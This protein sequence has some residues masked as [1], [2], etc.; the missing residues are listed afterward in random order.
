MIQRVDITFYDSY[1]NTNEI[2]QIHIADENFTLAFGIFDEYDYPF[3]DE[4]I[5]FPEAYF[6]GQ[7]V[8]EVK[9]ERCDL[10]K[11]SPEFKN[12]FDE[13]EMSNL[14]CLTNINYTLRPFTNALKIEL[15][16]CESNDEEG[17]YC[18]PKEFIDEYLNDKVFKIYFLDIMLTPANY[19]NPVQEK[20]KT[21]N[22][23]IYKTIRQYLYTQMQLVKIETSTNIIGFDFLTEPKVQDFLKFDSESMLPY[24]GYDLDDIYSYYP[25]SIFELQLND[26][27]L[28]EKRQYLQLIDVLGEIGGL[29]EIIFSFL[30]LISI[31]IVDTLYEKN[32]A[33]NLFSFN[34]NKRFILIKKENNSTFK[35]NKEIKEEQNL[36]DKNLSLYPFVKRKKKKK[37][38]VK[39]V[40][41]QTWNKEINSKTSRNIVV[42]SLGNEIKIHNFENQ[43][44][45]N[46]EKYTIKNR[47][48]S[49]YNIDKNIKTSQFNEKDWIITNIG[50]K[51]LFISKFHCG[52][53][54]KRNVYNLLL[55]ESMEV[56]ME[57]LDI[58]NIFR[59]IYSIENINNDLKNNLDEIKMSKEC[60]KNLSE[61]IK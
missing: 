57:K 1:S 44:I 52:K 54:K 17:D 22:T 41:L 27:I 18:E 23:Q 9:I 29:M 13:S 6:H 45:K 48:E 51:E 30:S 26:K 12:N 11:L 37:V 60:S 35:I 2:P 34:V 50:L 38:K 16:P 42:N 46:S 5:Y 59:N 10:S 7:G 24:P 40:N 19:E 15:Y 61:I 8:E 3:I 55:N 56:I 36:N 58:F 32:L 33:N 21:L 31:L 25:Y 49:D 28:L 14:Y 39:V 43:S 4:T 47:E 53:R 20:L